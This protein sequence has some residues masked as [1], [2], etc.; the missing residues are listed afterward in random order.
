MANSPSHKLGE[1]IG[2]FFEDAIV[3]YL[4]P[5]VD[6]KGFYLDYRHS[7]KA[8]NGG[9][10]VVGIDAEGNKH[11][12]DIVIEEDGS[13]NKLGR[14]RAFI[15]IAW[16][17][18]TK[19]S[20][21]KAQEISGAILPLVETYKQNNPF[22][23]AVL[24]G[25]FT[26]NSITQ[27]QSQRFYVEH[28]SYEDICQLYKDAV[29]IEVAWKERT[30]D[31]DIEKIAACVKGL[32]ATKKQTLKDN[33]YSR[34]K[35]KL[36]ALANA[37]EESLNQPVTQI[38]IVP[39]HGKEQI[40]LSVDDAVEYIQNYNEDSKEPILRYEITMKYANGE[41]FVMECGNKHKAIRRL[42]EYK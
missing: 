41:E 24:L 28:I 36:E 4:K 27:L 37:V 33:F 10:E 23:A 31:A 11:K 42:N 1:I 35:N 29:G 38:M 13:E 34:N 16:R 7:R 6:K 30:P 9:K 40:L 19:H 3:E 20:K 15:E 12:L 32:S 14:P 8:R 25:N 2:T 21:A 18:Y 17:S 26:Q 39:I 5:L 22:Y